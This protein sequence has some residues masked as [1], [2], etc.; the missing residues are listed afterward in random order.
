MTTWSKDEWILRA[1]A[2]GQI[3]VTRSG[4]VFRRKASVENGVILGSYVPQVLSTHKH[5]GRVYFQLSFEG[6]TKSVLINRVVGLVYI[7]NPENKPEVNHIDGDKANNALDNLEWSTRQEQELHA[8]R[9]GLKA[10]RGSS[11]S[12]AKLTAAE[13]L[14]IREAA[15]T[16][17]SELSRTFGVSRKTITDIKSRATWSHI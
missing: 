17:I 13:V 14:E 2:S 8:Q 10:N 7:P 11:N 6:I 3:K 12:N 16:S 15:K 5:S 4:R 1:V 9:N